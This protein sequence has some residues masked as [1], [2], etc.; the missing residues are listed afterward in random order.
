M[1]AL[2]VPPGMVPRSPL[3]PALM[4]VLRIVVPQFQDLRHHAVHLA[5]P[6]VGDLVDLLRLA[7]FRPLI[8][9]DEGDAGS[10]LF[11]GFLGLLLHL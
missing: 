6:E 1:I 11:F 2:F 3:F 9:L 10:L 7:H 8:L 5:I 4:P